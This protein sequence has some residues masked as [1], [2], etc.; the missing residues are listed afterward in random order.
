MLRPVVH[1]TIVKQANYDIKPFAKELA[2]NVSVVILK[3]KKRK[4]E[5]EKK[6]ELRC[7]EG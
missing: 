7:A 5:K 6:K 3:K 2:T 4:K 1:S